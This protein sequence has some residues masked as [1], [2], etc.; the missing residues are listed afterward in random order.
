MVVFRF[1]ICI[2]ALISLFSGFAN[3]LLAQ[4][5]K[6]PD[7]QE[8]A[9]KGFDHVYS[10]DYEDARRAFHNLRQRNGETIDTTGF[11]SCLGPPKISAVVLTKMSKGPSRDLILCCC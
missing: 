5:L 1:A 7:F 4:S 3:P 10:L 9:A 6:T 11:P 8:G 2:A